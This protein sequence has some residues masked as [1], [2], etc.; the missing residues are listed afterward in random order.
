MGGVKP[1]MAFPR[2]AMA[3]CAGRSMNSWPHFEWI[4][5]HPQPFSA[6]RNVWSHEHGVVE[7]QGRPTLAL[8]ATWAELALRWR[9][10]SRSLFQVFVLAFTLALSRKLSQAPRFRPLNWPEPSKAGGPFGSLSVYAPE[11]AEA[12]TAT[13]CRLWRRR[14]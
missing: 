1:R 2:R 5:S 10:P 14:R 12:Q 7:Q 11:I 13:T 8:L 6:G 3:A 4:G 9:P